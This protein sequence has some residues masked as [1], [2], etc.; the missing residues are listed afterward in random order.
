[1]SMPFFRPREH[2]RFVGDCMPF[3]H[4]GVFR[5]YHLIDEGHHAALGGL[6]G[7]QWGQISSRDLRQ[8]EEHPIA[9]PIRDPR[10]GSICTGSVFF[11]RG[12]YHAFYATRLPD[13]SQQLGLAISSDGVHFE[14]V[15]F[16]LASPA[17]GYASEHYRDPVVFSDPATGEFHLLATA[18]WERHP[19]AGRGGCL[20]HLVSR[21]LRMWT[22]REPFA[23]PGFTDVPEC[24]DHFEW[25]GWHYLV[26]SNHGIARY[27]MSRHGPLGPWFRPAVDL[28]DGGASRVMK[29]APFAGNRRIG[30]S[31]IG[32]REGAK[33]NGALQFGGN[34]VFRE[35]VQHGDGTLGTRFVEEVMP[36]EGSVLDRRPVP[37]TAGVSVA[38][39]AVRIQPGLGL[40]AALLSDLPSRYRLSAQVVVGDGTGAVGLRIRCGSGGGQGYDLAIDPTDATV[41]LNAHRLTRVDSV[42]RGVE[43]HLEFVVYDTL[44]DVCINRDRCLIDRCPQQDGN[45]LLF[46]GWDAGVE[47][48]DVRIAA[49]SDRG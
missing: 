40:E 49:Y 45:G 42:R 21:D 26:Y 24:P 13:W 47:F 31:W 46:Y 35:L 8:W 12:T 36:S 9:L 33:D 43:F 16:D 15:L 27:R 4:D 25:N 34:G 14:K 44:I 41:T 23:I 2:D 29:T 17:P 6:G 1:M 18:L 37:L 28:L 22:L 30:V 5:L 39:A 38:E 20:A 48:R 19:V 3:Y 10:E 11:H 32:T 7:H